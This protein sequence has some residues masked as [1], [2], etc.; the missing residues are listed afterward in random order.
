LHLVVPNVTTSKNHS[1]NSLQRLAIGSA[2]LAAVAAVSDQKRSTLADPLVGA[3]ALLILAA[4]AT[5]AVLPGDS[6]V[7]NLGLIAAVVAYLLASQAAVIV[8]NLRRSKPPVT[9]GVETGDGVGGDEAIAHR[10]ASRRS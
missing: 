6:R 8:R 10:S 5:G 2:V 4:G 9:T 7:A 1:D 3:A